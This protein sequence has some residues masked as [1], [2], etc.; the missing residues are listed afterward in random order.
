M[1]F[2]RSGRSD[3]V[4]ADLPGHLLQRG[5][6]LLVNKLELCDKVVEML[7]A[8]VNVGL[9]AYAHDSVEVVN[10][11]VDKHTIQTSQDL[12]AL[13]LKSLREGDI[14]SDRKQ[15]FIIDLGLDPVH[16]ESNVLRG[17]EVSGLLILG[18]V[19]PQILELCSPGHRWTAL[20]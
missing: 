20:P 18:A 4:S 7:V 19:L 12:L 6:L 10:I 17:R 13:R 9:G 3:D 5:E 8:G 14:S 1:G 16:E 2:F 15:I 11:H